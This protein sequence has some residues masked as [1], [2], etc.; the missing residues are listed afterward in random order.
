MPG[1]PAAAAVPRRLDLDGDLAAALDALPPKQRRAVAYHY[2]ADLP[3]AEVAAIVGGTPEAARRAAAD[4]IA[5]L[6]RATSAA[7][8]TPPPPSPPPPLRRRRPDEHPRRHRLHPP[9]PRRHERRCPSADAAV[10]SPRPG[11]ALAPTEQDRRDLHERLVAAAGDRGLIDVAYRT[12]DTPIGPLLLAATDDGLVR[13]AFDA[14]DHDAVLE[15]LAE[16]ISPR[17]L[18][19]PGRL[20]RAAA[21]L[22]EY[23][24]GRR[25]DFDLPLDWRLSHGFRLSVLRRLVDD[26]GYGRTA[27][28][29]G[30]RSWSATPGRCAPSAAPAPPTPSPSSCPAT[31]WCAPTG[32]GWLPGRP[33][34]QAA[35]AR[36]RAGGVSQPAG[37]GAGR[38]AGRVDACD[39]DPHRGR[40]R[41]LGG[42]PIGPLL[43]RAG[44]RRA[45]RALRRHA[46]FRS[47]VD[48]AAHR[49]GEGSYR[50]FA[51]PLPEAVGA[52]RE[53]LYPRLLPV[54]RDWWS[55]PRSGGA[56]A[57]RPRRLA[58]SVPRRRPDAAHPA[59]ARLRAGGWNALHR[60]LYG[61]AVF[62][63]QVVI[64]LTG[65]ASTTPAAS[66]CSWSS[67]PGPSPG[68]PSSRSPTGTGWCSPPATDRCARRAAGPP[69]PVR[70]GVSVVR[71]GRRVTLGLVFHDAA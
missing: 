49:F 71:S 24:A 45:G 56:V 21:E 39:W 35:A 25:R 11:Q 53:A 54:A 22:D 42:A 55:A 51:H 69:A 50:Y 19:A 70:H 9:R 66:W 7:T 15:A 52:L 31:E 38:V 23:F 3:Y 68:R 32:D 33:R 10:A 18:R 59:P 65:P 4:G 13:I 20:D 5:A 67:G 48:M 44:D 27:T 40:A 58:G 63:L 43:H 64:N 34:R 30:W 12:L 61:E 41:Q 16:R 1:A 8:P 26:V 62:P 29:S 17:I 57:G 36:P 14:E 2:L 6:R 37:G 47:T 28:Y 46:R 60:D